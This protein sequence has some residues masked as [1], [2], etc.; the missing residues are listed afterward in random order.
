MKEIWED[1]PNY[2]GL[3]QASNLG[4]IK[5][6]RKVL[7]PNYTQNGY[8][9][10]QLSKNGKTKTYLVHLL[11]KRA[12]DGYNN[13]QVDHK[14]GNKSNNCLDNLEYVTQQE[15]TIRAWNNNLIS[16]KENKIDQY[17][18]SDNFIK[19]WFNCGDIE[20]YLNLDHSNIIKCCKGKRK[21]CGGYIWKYNQEQNQ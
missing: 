16:R 7:K 8:L 1:I 10:V 11:V 17:D 4:R 13:L 3:Y 20:K 2:E 21:Q 9:K 14:D 19:T 5:S 15:N 6:K 12:F 18:L